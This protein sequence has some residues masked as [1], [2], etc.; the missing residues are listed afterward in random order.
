VF[1]VACGTGRWAAWFADRGAS[2]LGIDICAEMLARAPARLHGRLVLG[3]AEALP[4]AANSADLTLCSFAAG[5]FPGLELAISEMARIT[6]SGG[7]L[8][9]GD[10]HP[11]AVAAGW[12]RSFRAGG[13]V[14]EME[15]FAYRVEDFTE[16]AHRAG[17]DF[18]SE[19]HGYF[20]ELEKP[21]FEKAGRLER[22]AQLTGVPAVW[23]GRW[24][25]A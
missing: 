23:I 21:A 9:I 16:A 12:T 15:H 2:V 25:K 24:R 1:D 8:V 20:G 5:Y 22:F 13:C 3:C 7:Y 14:Y 17:F 4:I 11:A 10:L 19:V 6:R 18:D